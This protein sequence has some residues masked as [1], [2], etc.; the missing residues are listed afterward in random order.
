MPV[1]NFIA[2]LDL[3]QNTLFL[4]GHYLNILKKPG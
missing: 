1:V 4:D 3:E 2:C